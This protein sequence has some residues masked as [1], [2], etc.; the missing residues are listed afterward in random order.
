MWNDER[1]GL[2]EWVAILV[3]ILVSALF[4]DIARDMVNARIRFIQSKTSVQVKC[5]PVKPLLLEIQRLKKERS[6]FERLYL[7]CRI[8]SALEVKR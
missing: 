1:G 3:L 4:L 5:E 2:P 6:E 8:P 7:E